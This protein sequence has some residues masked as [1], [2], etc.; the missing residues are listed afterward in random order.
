M[1]GSL[2]T[3]PTRPGSVAAAAGLVNYMSGA[4]VLAQFAAESTLL[5]DFDTTEANLRQEVSEPNQD[6]S[7][8]S[9]LQKKVAAQLANSTKSLHSKCNSTVEPLRAV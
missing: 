6:D 2:R 7:S 1:S 8:T 4:A 5:L 3:S 9:G